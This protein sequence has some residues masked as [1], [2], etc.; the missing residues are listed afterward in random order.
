METKIETITPETAEVY[1]QHNP[2]NRN[3]SS[4]RVSMYARS[5]R[6]GNWRLTHQGLAFNCDGSLKDGQHRLAAIVEAGV[7]VTM[8]VTRG[9][10]DDAMMGIDLLRPRTFVDVFKTRG[11]DI[12]KASVAVARVLWQVYNEQVL[13][14]GPRSLKSDADAD[15]LL[16][17]LEH[18]A[19]AIEFAMV[20]ANKNGIKAAPVRAAIA[21]AWWTAD[22]ERLT[23]FRDTLSSGVVDNVARD[24]AVLRLRD[25]LLNSPTLNGSTA[26]REVYG[27][28]CT[29]LLA[30]IEERNLTK[31]Y[32]RKDAI[33]KLPHVPGIELIGE[34]E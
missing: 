24:G 3:I 5:M 34:E 10:S 23:Q 17:F 9:L 11:L 25:V 31:L 2:R 15:T 19:E 8:M 26:R 16:L 14:Y 13:G 33:F 20:N 21:S 12:D 30:F 1:L 28:V 22:I 27:R 18:H 7:P 4:K 29:A 6:A 32:W